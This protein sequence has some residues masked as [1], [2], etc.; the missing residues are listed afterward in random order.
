MTSSS[1]AYGV[2][3]LTRGAATLPPGRY[4]MLTNDAAR[5]VD[6]ATLSRVAVVQAGV[7]LRR[8]FSPEHGIAADAADGARVADGVDAATGLEIVSLYGERLRPL[9]AA[10]ADLDGVLVD[11][12]DIGARFYTYIWSLSHLLEV[13]GEL[14][15][16]ITV[17]DRPNPI[18]GDLTAAEGPL[19]DVDACSGFLGRYPMP[20]RHSLTIGELARLWNAEE[21]LGVELTVVPT[22]GWD[23]G[24]HQ[25]ATG[26]PFVPTSPAI[27]CYESALLYPGVCLF[28]A[29]NLSV[30]R[31]TPQAFQQVGAPW[32][33]ADAACEAFNK[34][35]LPGI[36]SEAVAFT[37]TLE[38]HAGE[39]CQ[40]VRLIVTDPAEVRPVAAGLALL[41]IV[42]RQSPGAFAWRP[43]PTAANP[44]GER[45]FDLLVGRRGVGELLADSHRDL[46]RLVAELTAAPGWRERA[47]PH[48]LY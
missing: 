44:S 15:L 3:Q 8:L 41:A 22:A 45:H 31:R 12:P 36:A 11:L 39:R 26:A 43:Y 1:I 32:L 37:P 24:D 30:G 21:Q 38:P 17:L 19:L 4:G 29:T 42:M 7:E 5:T 10:L 14:G 47:E 18:G 13:G 33:D 46:P 16:P 6:G 20:V 34:A 48:L 35:A 9:P 28:E 25:P 27:A 2:D 23:R 40:G